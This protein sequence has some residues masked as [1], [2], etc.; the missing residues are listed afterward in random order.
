M[1]KEDGGYFNQKLIFGILIIS[2]IAPFIEIPIEKI[3]LK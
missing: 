2:N 3:I 1:L